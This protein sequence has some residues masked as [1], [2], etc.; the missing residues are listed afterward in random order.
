MDHNIE[1]KI[2]FSLDSFTSNLQE[3]FRYLYEEQTFSD[4]TLVTDDQRQIK[5]HKFILSKSCSTFTSILKNI[6]FLNPIIVLRDIKYKDLKLILDFIYLGHV[7]IEKDGLEEFLSIAECLKLDDVDRIFQKMVSGENGNKNKS[8]GNITTNFDKVNEYFEFES[9]T[10]E[11]DGNESEKVVPE[12]ETSL[13]TIIIDDEEDENESMNKNKE[14]LKSTHSSVCSERSETNTS[15]TDKVIQNLELE[16]IVSNSDTNE[17]SQIQAT[18]CTFCGVKFHSKER[19]L[20]HFKSELTFCG[21]KYK[22]NQCHYQ[23]VDKIDFKSH[24]VKEHVVEYSCEKCEFISN[25]KVYLYYHVKNMHGTVTHYCQDCEF[26]SKSKQNL[27]T[28]IQ[29]IHENIY[30][31][32]QQCEFQTARKRNL[33][34]HIQS[35][36]EKRKFPCHQ[37]DYKA[38]SKSLLWSHVQ[39]NHKKITHPCSKCEYKAT[40]K[41]N[42]IKHERSMH[43]NIKLPCKE[44]GFEFT[45]PSNLKKHKQSKH[46]KLLY[47]CPQ[48]SQ[49]YT[50]KY[51]MRKHVQRYH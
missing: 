45:D 20:E 25:K 46:L 14:Y 35:I 3:L 5:A 39:S 43:L 11:Q 6:D 27:K 49:S 32:C 16:N 34:S 31:N 9:V 40:R 41:E 42:L 1:D 7:S 4:V 48:C 28:H 13:P 26:K 47:P 24:Q 37:C 50:K 29:S 17:M 19:L 22:C 12:I 2:E 44:C 51:D 21:T 15:M 18:E 30:F 8:Q 10:D 36:H 38:S 33:K 23:A